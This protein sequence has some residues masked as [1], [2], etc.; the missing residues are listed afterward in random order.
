MHNTYPSALVNNL[1]KNSLH[2]LFLLF[3]PFF[4]LSG[5]YIMV[6]AV[7]LTLAGGQV[8]IIEMHNT[9]PSVLVNGLDRNALYALFPPVSSLFPSVKGIYYGKYYGLD[10]CRR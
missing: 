10:S 7:V 9:Y 1:D 8:W 2:D 4:F 6:N 3:P 5:L